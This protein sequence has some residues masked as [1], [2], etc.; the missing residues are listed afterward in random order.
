MAWRT[1][2]RQCRRAPSSDTFQARPSRGSAELCGHPR[3]N[4]Y[5][6]KTESKAVGAADAGALEIKDTRTGT[7]YTVPILPPGTEGDT[8]I[9]AMDLRQIKQRPDEFG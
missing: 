8:A 3:G 7:G 1:G 9:R 5:M 6:G 4:A 2:R